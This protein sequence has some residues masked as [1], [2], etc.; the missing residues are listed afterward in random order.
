ME[1]QWIDKNVNLSALVNYI[2]RFFEERRFLTSI[3]SS[4]EG[5]S[6]IATPRPFHGIVEKIN[7]CITGDPNSFKVKFDAG[8][9]SD[10]WVKLGM[11]TSFFG[12]GFFTLKG[13]KSQEALEKL[14]KE[15]WKYVDSVVWSLAQPKR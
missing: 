12:G 6:I 10:K 11:L 1:D 8:F 14:E 9:H 13:L 5:F 2:V 7:V 15:F 3:K 4:A